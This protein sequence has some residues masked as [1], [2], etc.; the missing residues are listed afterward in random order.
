MEKF[1]IKYNKVMLGES[2]V[3]FSYRTPNLPFFTF[4]ELG[5]FIEES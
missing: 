1:L 3:D 4:D 2:L 5:A